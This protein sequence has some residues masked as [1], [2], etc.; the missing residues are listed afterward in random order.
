MASDMPNLIISPDRLNY[1]SVPILEQWKNDTTLSY[2]MKN[3]QESI[4]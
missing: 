4:N 3:I 2:E 1:F